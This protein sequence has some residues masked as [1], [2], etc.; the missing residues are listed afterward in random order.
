[1]AV[2]IPGE[3]NPVTLSSWERKLFEYF[4]NDLSDDY[5]VLHS[6]GVTDHPKKLWAEADYM[7]ISPRGVFIIEVK[8]GGIEFKDGIWTYIEHNGKRHVNHEGPFAQA[9]EIMFAVKKRIEEDERNRGFAF[10]YG[11]IMPDEEFTCSSPETDLNVVLSKHNW[12]DGLKSYFRN[13]ENYWVEKNKK[14]SCYDL[15]ALDKSKREVVLKLL[16]PNIKTAYTL[17]S[18]LNKLED[19]LVEL[20]EAQFRVLKNM[21]ENSRTVTT[22]GTGTGKTIL[23]LEKAKSLAED[24]NRVLFLCFTLL[25][26]DNLRENIEDGCNITVDAIHRYMKSVI[27]YQ[28]QGDRLIIDGIKESDLFNTVYPEVYCD[29]LLNSKDFELFDCMVIDEAQDLLTDKNIDALD[30]TIKGGLKDGS[31]HFFLDP[32]QDIFN[33]FSIIGKEILKERYSPAFCKLTQNCRNTKEIVELTSLISSIDTKSNCTCE[34]GFTK[35]VIYQNPEDFKRK[36]E[37]EVKTLLDGRLT[38]ADFIILS[39][40]KLDNSIICDVG[41]VAG[42]YVSDIRTPL[43]HSASITCDDRSATDEHEADS[44]DFC[45]MHAFKGLE[46][47]AVLAVDIEPPS[48][49]PR[50][51]LLYSGLS[52]AKCYLVVFVHKDNVGILR[53]ADKKG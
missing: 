52:R 5:Y 14:S 16:R 41:K 12:D 31:W 25:L 24:G 32:N 3:I 49:D 33:N 37:L 38:L 39:T 35:V 29:V 51:C 2:M 11:V 6:V 36:I 10:G 27:V 44:I 45:T 18:R 8:G 4:R 46:R 40:K 23:A 34:G 28:G 22:G 53:F 19:R 42:Y 7:I 20:T 17:K 48:D 15:L 47:K 9:K 30:L 21:D 26:A 1:M 43:F 13:L 50:K